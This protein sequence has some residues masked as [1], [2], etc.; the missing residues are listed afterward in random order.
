MLKHYLKYLAVFAVLATLMVTSVSAQ[1][2]PEPIA[3]GE[4]KT[5]E[6]SLSNIA[7]SYS[8]VAS[9][10]QGVS[11][12]VL[13]ITGGFAP[14]LRILDPNGAVVENQPNAGAASIIEATLNPTVPGAYIFEVQS[15]NGAGGQFL[16][17]IQAAQIITV[18][19]IPLVVGQPVPGTVGPQTPLQVYSF[20][21][22]PTDI[23]VLTIT[24]N[25]GTGGPDATLKDGVSNEPL[26]MGSSRLIGVRFRIPP[27]AGNFLVDLKHSGLNP[28]EPYTILLEIESTGPAETPEA[29]PGGGVGVNIPAGGPCMVGVTGPGNVNVRSGPDLGFPV[30]T[31]LAAGQTT[32]VLA[33]SPG[34]GWYQININGVTGWVASTVSVVGGQC[35]SVPVVNIPPPSSGATGTPQPTATF[36]P[37]STTGPTAT[38]GPTSTTGPTATFGPTS[39]T[40]PTATFGPTST[41]PP[42]AIPPEETPES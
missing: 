21:A 6:V 37:T 34:G 38:F 27:G 31:Q 2:A 19:P 33:Q 11:V 40:G 12:Q 22:S 30:V 4:N 24:S 20:N 42:T 15:A 23:L 5:G 29:Q 35:G 7:P 18:P 28:N 41:P 3:I 16:I 32:A 13:A 1:T 17:T 39:T 26:G 36:G 14:S 10:G 8:F 25:L 9:P